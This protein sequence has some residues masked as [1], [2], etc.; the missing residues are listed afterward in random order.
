[1]DEQVRQAIIDAMT[2]KTILRGAERLAEAV[3][4]GEMDIDSAQAV[5][6]AV[7]LPEEEER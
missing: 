2:Q 6:D 4:A 5:L 7:L 1:M 3:R